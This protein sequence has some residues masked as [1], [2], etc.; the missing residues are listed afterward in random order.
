M[1]DTIQPPGAATSEAIKPRNA[2]ELTDAVKWAVERGR[3][4]RIF[5]GDSKSG[6]GHD[7]PA[8]A[9]PLDLSL[10]R[11]IGLYQPEELVLSAAPATPLKEI[12]AVLAQ[13]NQMLA[14]EPPDFTALYGPSGIANGVKAHGAA[15]G[16][17]TIGGIVACNLSGP[18]RL[19]AG[20]LRDHLLGFQA[21][22]GRGER[23]KSGG[24]VMKNVT[25]YD[26]SK[27]MAGSFGTLAV[28]D[29]ITVKVLPAPEKTRTVLVYG[30]ED[31]QAVSLLCRAMGEP[32]DVSGAAHLPASVAARSSV[33]R[34]GK[35]GAPV[36]ALRLE[37][38]GPSVEA[39]CRHLRDFVGNAAATEELHS[40]NSV[41]LWTE[42]RDVVL[43]AQPSERNIW[44]LSLAPS[45]AAAIVAAIRTARPLAEAFYDWSGGLVW[46]ALPPNAGEGD[47]GQ[48]LVR[49]AVGAHGHATLMRAPAA[50][51]AQVQ[52]FQPLPP[53]LA[54]L[55][56]RVKDAFDPRNVLN[57]GRLG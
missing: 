39:R 7:V 52:V 2:E 34:V 53:P 35:A 8:E 28:L 40:V 26:L 1:S 56:L 41:A 21:T 22:S 43:L 30:L 10:L 46:L 11:G 49:F 14:F 38:P 31:A 25:G 37:G 4:L 42:L 36:T 23:F 12:E 24:R 54:A 20:A 29:E 18:R 48:S 19:S 16:G 32:V 13:R 51:R 47:A 9:M 45:D 6:F 44:R 57:P 3:Y 55:G 27:L 33:D 17:P 5:G 15:L 50:L